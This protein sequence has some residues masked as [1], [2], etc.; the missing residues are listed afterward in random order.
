MEN[1]FASADLSAPRGGR[2][3]TQGSA[4]QSLKNFMS[5]PNRVAVF[6]RAL[7]SIS[8]AKSQ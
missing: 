7:F 2:R 4:L 6:G 1:T 8:F 5:H 3:D